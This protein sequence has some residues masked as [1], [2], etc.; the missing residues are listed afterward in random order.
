[1]DYRENPAVS[2]QLIRAVQARTEELD[3]REPG[4]HSSDLIYCLRKA[5]YRLN[6]EVEAERT[7][8]GNLTLLIGKGFHTLLE[9]GK[10]ED[11]VIL[12]TAA[13]PVH[14]TIDI[15]EYEDG[16]PIPVELKST[17][18]RAK[19][20]PIDS[21]H[22]LEQLATYCVMLGVTLGRLIVVHL[23]EPTIKAWD[24]EFAKSELDQWADEL[25][26]RALIVADT[27]LHP[28]PGDHWG[29][30]C[31]YCS[32]HNTLCPGDGGKPQGVGF[33]GMDSM[34]LRPRE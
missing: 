27:Q 10:A 12:D 6:G 33:F 23:S 29:W 22:Y 30:E 21:P 14:G 2:D 25:E 7:T 11:R 16:L 13:G 18:A 1:L 19:K 3:A 17:R 8:D 32:F 9:Q 24:V 26:S 5:W 28:M 31:K 4:L 34:T 15:V 20:P